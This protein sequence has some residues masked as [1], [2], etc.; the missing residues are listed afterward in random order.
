MLIFSV[1]LSL[2]YQFH[3]FNSIVE[4]FTKSRITPL[5]PK[6]LDDFRTLHWSLVQATRSTTQILGLITGTVFVGNALYLF[7]R[8]YNGLEEDLNHPR[9][10]IAFEAVYAFVYLVIR[11]FCSAWSAARLASEATQSLRFLHD[12]PLPE[13]DS[14]LHFLLVR[15]RFDVTI[16]SLRLD[17]VINLKYGYYLYRR[18]GW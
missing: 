12:Q 6:L 17:G 13:N 9:L 10:F 7:S 8:V 15:F 2:T 18:R 1:S 5:G 14:L 3:R 4:E 11:I 16:I